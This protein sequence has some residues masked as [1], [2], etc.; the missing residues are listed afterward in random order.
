TTYS[1]PGWHYAC[2]ESGYTDSKISFT[3][4]TRVFNP[5]TK[6]RAGPKPRMLMCNR[7]GTHE[8][9][10]ILQFCLENNILLCCLPSHT[11]HK[12]QPCDV[13]VF[14]PLK[15]AYRDQVELLYRGGANTVGK[16][17]FTALYSVVREKAFMPN[18]IRAGWGKCGLYPFNPDR[19]L[20]DI[21]KPPA[22]LTVP[23]FNIAALSSPRTP[24]TADTLI[25]L[26]SLVERDTHAL[27]DKSKLRLEKVLNAAQISFAERALLEDDNRLLIKHNNEAKHRRSTKSTVL[28]RA[29]VI[30]YKDLKEARAKRAAKE[31][32]TSKER[33]GRKRKSPSGKGV[34]ARKDKKAR[35]SE[36]EAAEDKIVA[37]GIENHCSILQL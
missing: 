28:G 35:K 18:N 2:S 20:Q 9:L 6:E 25:A 23:K 14:G 26:R 12:L 21:R 7:F 3:W 4:L 15:A 13:G 36:L 24:A 34:V 16:E 27:D 19:V 29:K 1:T 11:S 31:A 22:E 5:Q 8:T 30:S 37:A 32:E 10:E 33:R 17:H